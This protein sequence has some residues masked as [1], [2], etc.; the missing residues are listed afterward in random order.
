MA[1]IKSVFKDEVSPP[2]TS[3]KNSDGDGNETKKDNEE[4]DCQCLISWKFKWHNNFYKIY[5][6]IFF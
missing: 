2:R 1:D 3:L 6:S 5:D 4:R